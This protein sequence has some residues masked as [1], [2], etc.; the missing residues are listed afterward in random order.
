MLPAHPRSPHHQQKRR[1]QKRRVHS[2]L[3]LPLPL[4]LPARSR[5][6]QKRQVRSPLGTH[7]T[8]PSPY[9]VATAAMA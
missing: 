1:V 3:P 5:L 9:V 4:V 7:P 6:P 2:P 8:S